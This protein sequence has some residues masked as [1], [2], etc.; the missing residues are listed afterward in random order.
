VWLITPVVS[1]LIQQ[2]TRN[3]TTAT[4]TRG[5]CAQTSLAFGERILDI[6]DNT[7]SDLSYNPANGKL[8]VNKEAVLRSKLRIET[9]AVTDGLPASGG[10][11]D[12]QQVNVKSDF[13]SLLPVLPLHQTLVR[14]GMNVS[15]G[16][17]AA[18]AERPPSKTEVRYRRRP[19][20]RP[21]SRA[22]A[23]SQVEKW[24]PLSLIASGPPRNVLRGDPGDP[25]WAWPRS[26]QYA[27]L[28]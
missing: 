12:R 24:R 4:R 3:F 26:G 16:W 2:C 1:Y 23:A 7:A 25:E 27:Q 28:A 14:L 20:P 8:S 17:K 9:Q 10:M 21:T 15:T 18:V 19:P 6:A 13:S 11:G 5:R 22:P